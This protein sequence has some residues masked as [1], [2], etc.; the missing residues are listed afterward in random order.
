MTWYTWSHTAV[1][2]AECEKITDADFDGVEVIDQPAAHP[3]DGKTWTNRDWASWVLNPE[4]R[5]H[6]YAFCAYLGLSKPALAVRN[7]DNFMVLALCLL[8]AALDC[9][10]KFQNNIQSK[11]NVPF[12]VSSRTVQKIRSGEMDLERDDIP[13]DMSKRFAFINEKELE[14][15]ES[16]ESRQSIG[17]T[18]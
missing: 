5:S 17:D 15:A 2:K 8:Y 1:R 18:Y 11:R 14:G 9:L 7:A 16:L 6:G 3:P 12:H 4:I 13:T 10:G